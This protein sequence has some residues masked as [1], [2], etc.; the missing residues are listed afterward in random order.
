MT[1]T[2]PPPKPVDWPINNAV[3]L[4][5]RMALTVIQ[6]TLP[7][8]DHTEARRRVAALLAEHGRLPLR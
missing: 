8:E 3:D 2:S 7:E 4:A 5:H 6:Q 1:W